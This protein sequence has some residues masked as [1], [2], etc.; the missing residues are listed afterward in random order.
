[1]MKTWFFGLFLAVYALNTMATDCTPY[2]DRIRKLEDLRRHGGSLK[3][4]ERWRAQ[5]DELSEK[6]TRCNRE[7]SIQIVSGSSQYP[8]SSRKSGKSS[9][10][11]RKTNSVDPQT[12]QLLATCNYWI[13]ESNNNP[14]TTN[15][16]FR[17]TACRALDTKLAKGD[18]PIP[19]ASVTLRSLNECIKPNNLIDKEVQECRQGL[20]EPLWK[21]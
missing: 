1:M 20:R 15:S 4:M 2:K 5:T 21:R 19:A 3:Q 18:Q 13:T 6:L 17:D 11:L 12:Q 9:Q 7:G 16:S 8:S 14:S 10:K